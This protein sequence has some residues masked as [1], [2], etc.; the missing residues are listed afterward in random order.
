MWDCWCPAVPAGVAAKPSSKELWASTVPHLSTQSRRDGM[1]VAELSICLCQMNQT[2]L[3]QCERKQ[4]LQRERTTIP[5]RH[6]FTAIICFLFHVGSH[7]DSYPMER[8]LEMPSCA[9]GYNPTACQEWSG[10]HCK[11]GL[12]CSLPGLQLLWASGPSLATSLVR[13]LRP[14][15]H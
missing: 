12:R 5:E 7:P 3:A 13:F 1:G 10:C 11:A 8:S 6:H 15:G 4:G 9:T 14:L 2:S